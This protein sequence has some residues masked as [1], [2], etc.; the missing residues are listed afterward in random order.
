M[1]LTPA[2]LAA[3]NR[4]GFLEFPGLLD[5]G[6]VVVL[7]GEVDR[8]SQLQA[9]EVKREGADGPP[10]IMLGMHL[11][12]SATASAAMRAAGTD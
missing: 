12:E 8:V 9:K 11:A 1:R 7:R 10:K 3:Y 4:D 6:E 2:Q 5:P